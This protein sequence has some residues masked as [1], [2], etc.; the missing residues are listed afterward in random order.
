MEEGAT[1]SRQPVSCPG[2]RRVVSGWDR[3]QERRAEEFVDYSGQRIIRDLL[4]EGGE[5]DR[6]ASNVPWVTW[7]SMGESSVGGNPGPE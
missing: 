2:E 3:E 7:E 6:G 1:E 4:D 5:D